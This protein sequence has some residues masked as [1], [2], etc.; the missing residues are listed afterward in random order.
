[1]WIVATFHALDSHDS[2]RRAAPSQS[3]EAKVSEDEQFTR[4]PNP[5]D[6]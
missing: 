1:M 4:P 3:L 5:M 2:A 6:G